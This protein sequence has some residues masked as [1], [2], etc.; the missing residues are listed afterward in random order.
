M[1][2]RA[3]LKTDPFWGVNILLTVLNEQGPILV[4]LCD[5]P[6]FCFPIENEK[7]NPILKNDNGDL[8]IVIHQWN[9]ECWSSASPTLVHH[10]SKKLHPQGTSSV[11]SSGPTEEFPAFW[12][13]QA[14]ESALARLMW[15]LGE[16]QFE[17]D[18]L[19]FVTRTYFSNETSTPAK[20]FISVMQSNWEA[21]S[22]KISKG[23]QWH[24][25]WWHSNYRGSMKIKLHTITG[26]C[27]F[28][29]VR[30]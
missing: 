24:A 30:G 21:F 12:E 7:I 17:M 28:P 8:P 1:H 6:T 11:P 26:L 29:R 19:I 14:E 16:R 15:L 20:Y 25:I 2:T 9:S 23:L 3:S 27:I 5:T 22:G 18:D 4:Y 13:R 10:K